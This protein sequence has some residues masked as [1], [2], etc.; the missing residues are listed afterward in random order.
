MEIKGSII[1]VKYKVL[2]ADRLAEADIKNMD[3]NKMPSY[4]IVNEAKHS[5]NSILPSK[6]D[7][8]DGLLKMILYSNLS[9]VEVDGVSM[10]SEAVLTLTSNKLKGT[11]SSKEPVGKRSKLLSNNNFTQGQ[12]N[13]L[14]VLLDEA[15]GNGFDVRIGNSK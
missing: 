15:V 8:K 2:L 7:I 4:C 5:K 1:G 11:L 3:V 10:K 13:F 14:D 9:D 6:G 12:V